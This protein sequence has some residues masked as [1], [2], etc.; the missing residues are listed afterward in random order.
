M[1]KY[2]KR[3]VREGEHK[4]LCGDTNTHVK[5][6]HV[7][8][9]NDLFTILLDESRDILIKEQIVITLRYVDN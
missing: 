8:I 9:S 5:Q 1:Q 6:N 3:K 2:F 4:F 7:K